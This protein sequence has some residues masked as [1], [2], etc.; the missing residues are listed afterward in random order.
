MAYAKEKFQWAED[1]KK[2]LLQI[3]L[4]GKD[5]KNYQFSWPE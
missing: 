1:Y 2:G 3:I 5:I 4:N